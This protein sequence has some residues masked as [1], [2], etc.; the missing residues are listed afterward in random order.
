MARFLARPYASAVDLLP[1]ASQV[2]VGLPAKV[3]N[4]C[5][6]ERAPG[7]RDELG[8]G[9]GQSVDDRGSR[10]STESSRRS[11]GEIQ[12]AGQA[13]EGIVRLRAE[14]PPS[15]TGIRQLRAARVP[16]V[17]SMKVRDAQGIHYVR[18]RRQQRRPR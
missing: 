3:L 12:L 5:L 14:R 17:P 16:G 13:V 18:R 6:A 11:P 4:S 7:D 2:V 8:V 9:S 10:L 1:E 15:G